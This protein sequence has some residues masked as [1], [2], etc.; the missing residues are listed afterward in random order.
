[1][2]AFQMLDYSMHVEIPCIIVHL[3]V[4]LPHRSERNWQVSVGVDMH[5]QVSPEKCVCVA[6]CIHS[7]DQGAYHRPEA[8]LV[9]VCV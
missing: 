3:T 1:M 4:P 5:E 6:V 7:G 8:I 2:E 9:C